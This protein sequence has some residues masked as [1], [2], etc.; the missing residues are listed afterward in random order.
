MIAYY[1]FKMTVMLA[2][3]VTAVGLLSAT[4]HHYRHADNTWIPRV[5][6]VACPVAAHTECQLGVAVTATNGAKTCQYFNQ[7]SGSS[8]TSKCY[9]TG[10]STSCVGSER[11][12]AGTDATKCLGHCTIDNPSGNLY[13]RNHADCEG[14]LKFKDY[15]L[16]NLTNSSEAPTDWLFYNSTTGDCY[17]EY[18]CHWYGARIII[19][20]YST[21]W[22]LSATSPHNCLDFLDMEN[23]ECIQSRAF[24]MG[25]S[26]SNTFFRNMLPKYSTSIVGTYNYQ[27]SLCYYWYKCG[28]VNNT[29]YADPQF[30][31]PEAKRSLQ[32]P[33]TTTVPPPKTLDDRRFEGFLDHL[34]SK[35][36][37]IGAQLA[38]RTKAIERLS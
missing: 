5:D 33:A 38:A 35:R 7:T 3:S 23:T 24:D 13:Q 22:Y 37:E 19:Y 1:V 10:T 25:V 29:Y 12:C 4:L 17:P 28:V 36:A 21:D 32:G 9:A 11:R 31:V 30:L 2:L 34:Q 8:C 16:M 26:F 15:Y 18:G 6:A 20:Q 14:K 27:G